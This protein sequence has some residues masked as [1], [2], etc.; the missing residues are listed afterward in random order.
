MQKNKLFLHVGSHKTGT[1]AI[2]RFAYLNRSTLRAKG[3]WYPD[4][5]PIDK[6]N[7][8]APHQLAKSFSGTEGKFS[9][10]QLTELLNY[11]EEKCKDCQLFVSAEPFF[12]LLEKN[13][14]GDWFYRREAYLS[15]VAD[16]LSR[17]E[18]DAVLV[19]Q[20]Q[21]FFVTSLYHEHIFAG[22]PTGSDSFEQF[23]SKMERTNLRYKDNIELMKKKFNNVR[24]ILY[25]E[26]ISD[27]NLCRIF[28]VG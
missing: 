22:L 17:F 10:R 24:I 8:K 21:D 3:F 12:R 23:L 4:F 14:N 26:L 15:R 1:T 7:I 13:I 19:L 5:Y 28:L 27:G 20:R 6:S 2:Q 11:W 16:F 9:N 18:V 25:D